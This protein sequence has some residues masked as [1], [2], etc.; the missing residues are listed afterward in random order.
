[1]TWRMNVESCGVCKC[2]YKSVHVCGGEVKEGFSREM[3]PEM[4][5]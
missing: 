3:V 2:V 1:M 5:V 4:K